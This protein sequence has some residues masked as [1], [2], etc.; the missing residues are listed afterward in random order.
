MPAAPAERP[1]PRPA[2][3]GLLSRLSGGA[4]SHRVGRPVSHIRARCLH[5]G[6]D[7]HLAWP[8]T[9]FVAAARKRGDFATARLLAIRPAA[10]A[11]TPAAD[12]PALAMPSVEDFAAEH[13]PDGFYTGKELLDLF[14]ARHA[15]AEPDAGA[16]LR[17]QQLN[18]R[19]R[20]RQIA[21]LGGRRSAP[22]TT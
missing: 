22:R 13:D 9:A 2:A 17:R 15:G 3:P 19:L 20:A 4:R 7:P 6:P 5:S 12:A 14:A 21:A 16:T 10:L 1:P 18:A 11:A 8:V